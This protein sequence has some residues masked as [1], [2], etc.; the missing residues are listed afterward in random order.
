MTPLLLLIASDSPRASK[1]RRALDE[2]GFRVCLEANQPVDLLVLASGAG[3]VE[4]C[5]AVPVFERTPML[6]WLE[7]PGDVG[8]VLR[9]GA[10][11][12]V[13]DTA[14]LSEVLARIEALL[15]RARHER[16][17]AVISFGGVLVD[18]RRGN[19]DMGKGAVPLTPKQL[20]LFSY[21]A[22][23]AGCVVARNELLREVWGS[24]VTET[25]TV[26]TH[27]AALRR[28]LETDPRRPEYL[29]TIRGRGYQFGQ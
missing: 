6:V 15:R 10:D 22:S 8:S 18:L 26:D 17:S 11:D 19:A 7:R 28:K 12:C 16:N 9:K 4:Q 14:D 27:M 20:H 21:L 1:L 13:A 23:H 5:R 3:P 24:S 2:A 25:R 29:F